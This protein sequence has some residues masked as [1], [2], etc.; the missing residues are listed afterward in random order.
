LRA[1]AAIC[2]VTAA[3]SN[4]T[5]NRRRGGEQV[6]M[7]SMAYHRTAVIDRDLLAG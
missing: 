5:P 2:T 6:L 4:P 7:T 3:T 1:I